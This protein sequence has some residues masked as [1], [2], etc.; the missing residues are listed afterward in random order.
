[1]NTSKQISPSE[2]T[3]RITVKRANSSLDAGAGS[4]TQDY[5]IL[6]TIWAKVDSMSSGRKQYLGLDAFLN[7][8]DI[9]F[10]YDSVPDLRANDV[11]DYDDGGTIQSLQVDQPQ[12]IKQNYKRF[13]MLIGKELTING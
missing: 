1:M 2:F 5:T 8:Y 12:L 10:R 7:V 6:A 13:W 9:C 3:R 11:I 4:Y